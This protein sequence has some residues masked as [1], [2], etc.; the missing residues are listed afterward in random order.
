MA[1]YRKNPPRLDR[2]TGKIR[3]PEN[4]HAMR[5]RALTFLANLC[6]FLSCLPGALA[7]L[8]ALAFPRHAQQRI[9]RRTLRRNRQTGYLRNRDFFSLPVTGYDALRQEIDAIRAGRPAVLTA[10]PVRVLQPTSGS[11]AAPK[12]I[13]FTAGLQRQFHAALAPWI[14]SLY[15]LRPR[16]LSGRQYWCLSPNTPA[17]DTAAP[18]PA[19]DSA[20]DSGAKSGSKSGARAGSG[21]GSSLAEKVPVGFADDTDYLG[22]WRAALAR[23]LLVAPPE[24]ARVAHPETFEFLTL[25]YLVAEKNLRLI[26]IWH[27]SFLTLLLDALPRHAPALAAT[28]LSGELPATLTLSADLRASLQTHLRASPRRAALVATLDLTA[29][30]APAR[31]WPRLQII[32]CWGGPDTRPWL[33]RLRTA[34]PA[35][36]IQPKG[37]LATEGVVTIPWGFSG[38]HVCAVNSHYYEF[39]PPSPLVPEATSADAMPAISSASTIRPLWRLTRDETATIILTTAGGLYRYRLGDRVRVTGYILRTPTLEFAG[40]EGIISDI[41]GEKLTLSDAEAALAVLRARTGNQFPFAM[42]VPDRSAR[43]PGYM[44][45]Y[46]PS[47]TGCDN[48]TGN[49]N[50]TQILETSLSGNYHYAHARR[51]NQLGP[52]MLRPVPPAAAARYRRRLTLAG[53]RHGDIKFPALR[54]EPGWPEWARSE[55]DPQLYHL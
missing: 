33:H 35:T 48:D 1:R 8:S 45:I 4:N 21:A 12:H 52:V 26:S 28:L 46:E 20:P 18:A 34:F 27:P 5:R 17:A 39:I 10:S 19:L 42:L 41:C 44:F 49:G 3:H 54:I 11:S 53:L 47:G 51:L 32:S 38:R 31:L 15:L 29:P 22:G 6:W 7:F 9:L 2:V 50:W 55:C 23:H 36:T 43:P 16:L 14:A 30:A 40:R 24:L 13:P 25:L 37:L